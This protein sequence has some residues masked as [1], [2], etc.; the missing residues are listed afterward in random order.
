MTQETVAF[1]N[2]LE[3]WRDQRFT[4][5]R[6]ADGYLSLAGLYWLTD[7]EHTFGS[8]SSNSIV[9]PTNAPLNIGTLVVLDSVVTMRV[10]P[11]VEVMVDDEAVGEMGM[12]DDAN[13]SPTI[14][15]LDSLNWRVINRSRGL[16][17]RLMDTESE[18]RR[19]FGGIDFFTPNRDWRLEAR[20]EP[21]DPP[22]EIVMPSI[23][24][25]DEKDTVPGV[26]VFEVEGAEYRLDVTGQPGDDRYFVVFGD[27][28]SGQETYGGGRFVWIDAED[29]E[30]NIIIDFNRA[31]NPPCVFSPF[32]T[33]PLPTPNNRLPLRI[34]AGELNYG[35]H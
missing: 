34:E 17:I 28:T 19:S 11:E 5:L 3:E 18:A 31:Y 12:V 10:R 2:D 22:L 6:K 35:G 23:T 9:F 4:N 1:N 21:Y 30:G 32:A 13:G 20:F 16:A 15:R 33:C 8:D 24:G 7:G 14:A 27:A 29:E 26:V 25:V